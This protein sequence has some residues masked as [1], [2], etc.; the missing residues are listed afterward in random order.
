M[1]R[2]RAFIAVD[3]APLPGLDSFLR[4]LSTVKGLKPVDANNLHVTLK[5]LGD[6]EE[7]L[8]PSIGEVM[9][10]SCEGIAPFQVQVIGSGVFPPKGSARVVWADLKGA[11]SLATIA[12]RLEKGLEPLGFVPE[13]RAFKS[14]LTMARVK[15]PNASTQARTIASSFQSTKFGSK[16]VTELLLKKSVLRPQG[17]EYSTVLALRLSS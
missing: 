4:D 3:L 5:F 13:S 16:E 17:P 10:T 9:R 6:V 8:V 11:E 12:A 15:D 1:A 14:H 7:S 2:F